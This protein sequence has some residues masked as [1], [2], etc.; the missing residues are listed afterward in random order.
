MLKR[1][2]GAAL[3]AAML[4]ACSGQPASAPAPEAGA[5]KS[6]KPVIAVVPKGLAQQ[7]WLTVKQGA[8][9][10]G[11]ELGADIVWQGPAKETEIA[12]QI[13]ILEDMINRGVDAIVMAACDENALVPTIQKAVDKGI[14]VITIDS[15][16]KSE[17]P[18]S[19]VATDN[20][21]GAK[22][23][24]EE[25][26]RLVGGAGQ[27][28]Q[29][30]IVPGAA[31]SEMRQSGF[32]EGIAAHPDIAIVGTQFCN[33]DVAKAMDVTRDMLT[34]NP[35]LK[36]VFAACEAAAIGAAQALKTA[37]RAGVVK[38][39]GF[40]AAEEQVALLKDGTIHALIVQNPFQMG[41]QGV[42][43]ALDTL[44]GKPV[45]KR[46]DTGV[47]VVTLDNLD[48]PEVQKLLNPA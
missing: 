30:P 27:V 36:G 10:A 8:D 43:A 12:K 34:A 22:A 44:A 35:E 9:T 48:T 29:I 24:A 6:G 46:I 47:V 18:L 2:M 40:D 19:F 17:L 28:A 4:G 14:P 25:L 13:G 1:W 38:L 41:F 20:V 11:A 21:A 15:G 33:S 45:E 39:V 26:A 37:G 5:E 3:V 42:Q 16:V 31:T 7:F 23:G 32:E